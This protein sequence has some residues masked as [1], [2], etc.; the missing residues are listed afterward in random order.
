ML[1]RL[2][3][4]LLAFVGVLACY[5]V[6][7]R[8]AV[9]VLE[10][11]AGAPGRNRSTPAERQTAADAVKQQRRDLDA[12]FSED[13]WERTSPKILETPQG[14]LLMRDYEHLPDGRVRIFPCTMVFMPEGTFATPEE[15]KRRAII[16]RAPQGAILQF[17]SAVNLK[18]GRIGKLIAGKLEGQITIRS[19]Q[20]LPG[21]E[22][23]L[24]IHAREVYLT[25][26]HLTT[27]HEIDF[28]LGKNRGSGRQLF[29]ELGANATPNAGQVS[30][31]GFGPLTS[32]ELA[33]DVK[34]R[35]EANGQDL[36]PGDMD[37]GGAVARVRARV[38]APPAGGLPPGPP[39]DVRCR[40]PFRF[41][42][43]QY[44][45]TF[46]DHVQVD[47]AGEQQTVD[48]LRCAHLA[49]YFETVAPSEAA[50][51]PAAASNAG[52][53]ELA[54]LSTARKPPKLVPW[55]LIAQGNPVVLSSPSRG[56]LLRGQQLDYNIKTG[57]GSLR[58]KREA[59]LRHEQPQ[60]GTRREIHA[61]LVQFQPDE[62]RRLGTF[63][64]EGA[65]W[66]EGDL[67]ASAQMPIHG[68]SARDEADN[69]VRIE[70]RWTQRLQFRPHDGLHVLS[71]VGQAHVASLATGELNAREIHLWLAEVPEGSTASSAGPAA[72]NL[73]P[74]RLLARTRVRFDSAQLTGNVEQLQI[75]F[76]YTDDPLSTAGAEPADANAA[77][78]GSLPPRDDERRAAGPREG[79]GRRRYDIKAETLQAQVTVRGS[80]NDLTEARI[81][82]DVVVKELAA[83]SLDG[84]G[85]E[86]HA[87]QVHMLEPQ[88]GQMT[89]SL[90]GTPASV[91]ARGTALQGTKITLDR[92]SNHL[93]AA[94]PGE[95]TLPAR[96]LDGLPA[97]VNDPLHI[98]WR[99][100]LNFDGLL[101][102]FSGDVLAQRTQ[103]SLRTEILEVTLDRRLQFGAN[104]GQTEPQVDRI[105]CPGKARLERRTMQ[106]G[107]PAS[108]ETMQFRDLNLVQKTGRFEAR[109]PGWVTSVRVGSAANLPMP[110]GGPGLG[111]R[112]SAA[113]AQG[114]ESG[115][116]P[117]SQGNSQADATGLT[118]LRVDFEQTVSGHFQRHEVAFDDQVRCVYG[119]VSDWDQV[120]DPEQPEQLGD[121]GFT[122]RTDRLAVAELRAQQGAEPSYELEAVG[123]TLVESST[124]TA[125]AHRLTYAQA[126]GLLVLR[127]DGRN[128]ARLFRQ[129][130][131]DGKTNTA[132]ARE[133]RY[134]PETNRVQV[135]DIQSFDVQELS[136]G[137]PRRQ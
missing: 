80:A 17:D 126:K 119:P 121:K 134:W 100:K 45:A 91:Q 130:S 50:P 123:N 55:R 132:A 68:A 112:T 10:P 76:S 40:G 81:Q 107:R 111:R 97:D 53:G 69:P 48:Q 51:A 52:H 101:A 115:E 28:Q 36:F 90:I 105:A 117:D 29:M 99:D 56:I 58:G 30:A 27:P 102:R 116:R 86:L 75:W 124:Y 23:D 44:V 64:A 24:L 1:A 57:A 41:D 33:H 7:S 61:P 9:S 46:E 25:E 8:V 70:A 59:I 88:P 120:L 128:D 6:Y 109:G 3:R 104:L 87:D 74:D 110:P 15:R 49:L 84:P 77:S 39:V 31:P 16:L 122:L 63:L 73:R 106:D 85:L 65:G 129:S 5:L 67:P 54:K 4:T 96:G 66:F 26:H 118:Y 89:V 93:R 98:T 113:S 133:I 37:R 137:T 35:L 20:R 136:G 21:P 34:L 131:V 18:Q 42:L 94:G 32:F 79:L 125:R 135:D 38:G 2:T 62:S 127:G 22:D 82:N 78:D 43:V 47:R 19:D 71:V 95:M 92:Q 60:L 103:E 114:T 14:K 11:V 13:E 72:G 83:A 108:M 12:W